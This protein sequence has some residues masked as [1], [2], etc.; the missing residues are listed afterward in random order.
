MCSRI[1]P[2]LC[3]LGDERDQTHLPTA[4]WAQQREHLVDAGDQH[5][6]PIPQTPHRRRTHDNEVAVQTNL[7]SSYVVTKMH[8]LVQAGAKAVNEGDSSDEQGCFVHIRRT[9]AE[10]LQALRDDPQKNAQHHV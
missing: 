7:Y 1:L 3:S 10:N 4:H 2:D 9:W 8:M 6:P 5:R